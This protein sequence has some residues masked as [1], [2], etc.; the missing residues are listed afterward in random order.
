[1]MRHMTNSRGLVISMVWFAML[2]TVSS[3][4][5]TEDFVR[6]AN[7]NI[8]SAGEL[9][10]SPRAMENT[11]FTWGG[12]ANAG[13]NA[14]KGRDNDKLFFQGGAV[15]RSN[16]VYTLFDSTGGNNADTVVDLSGPDAAI[17]LD[18]ARVDS[19]V[20]EFQFLVRT[21]PGQWFIS[22]ASLFLYGDTDEIELLL[23]SVTW[24]DIT[25]AETVLDPLVGED[26][27]RLQFGS[28]GQAP[29]LS[30][31]DGGGIYQI[32]TIEGQIRLN[33][34]AWKSGLITNE[35]PSVEAGDNLTVYLTDG[36]VA[37]VNATATDDGMPDP[38][39]TLS[40]GWTV[41]EQPQGS[42]VTFTPSATVEDPL[43]TFDS[44]GVYVLQVEADDSQL[45]ATDTVTINVFAQPLET[46]ELAPLDDT[47]VRQ[48]RA[49][50]THG[51]S[52]DLRVRNDGNWTSYLKF[53]TWDVPGNPASYILKL[54]ARD[55]ID[56]ARVFP[57]TY[58]PSGEW[59]EDSL[60]WAS[61]DL[62]NGEVLDSIAPIVKGQYY[63]FNV[64][65]LWIESQ[66]RA[67]LGLT[68]SGGAN[69]DFGSKEASEEE[70][71]QLIVR[72][73]PK[74]ARHPLTVDGAVEVHPAVV[75]NWLSGDGSTQDQ[76]FL[77]TD[78]NNLERIGTV[79]VTGSPDGETLDPFG[80]DELE[81]GQ[82]YYWQIVG[83]N[84]TDGSVW[85]FIV[86]ALHPD[87]PR[88]VTPEDGAADLI[89]PADLTFRYDTLPDAT[90][91]MFNLYVSSDVTR[92]EALDESVKIANVHEGYDPDKGI[93]ARGLVDY[94]PLTTYFYRF[95]GTDASGGSWANAI[96]R[97][98]TGFY[99]GVEEFETGLTD[100]NRG[101]AWTGDVRG[102]AVPHSGASSLQLNYTS[103]PS[104][105]TATFDRARNWNHVNI[106]TLTLFV[107]GMASNDEATLSVTLEDAAGLSTTVEGAVD[108]TDEDPWQALD[109]GLAKF[110]I[111]LGAVKTLSVAVTSAGAGTVYI[112][113][114][115]LYASLDE[116]GLLGFLARYPFDLDGR[117]AGPG[118]L[119]LAL[120]T[121]GSGSFEIA[122][123]TAVGSGSFRIHGFG[124][125]FENGA[126]AQKPGDDNLAV[127][128]GITVSLWMKE[129]STQ[130]DSPW[131]GLFGEGLDNPSTMRL[132]SFQMLRASDSRLRWQC[133]KTHD[134]NAAGDTRIFY[135][136]G[137]DGPDTRDGKWHHIVGAYDANLGY[138]LY[139]DGLQRLFAPGTGLIND[140]EDGVGIIVGA[141]D[142]EEV[143]GALT[144]DPTHFFF[145]WID[146]ILVYDRALVP[147]EVDLIYRQGAIIE[148]DLNGDGILD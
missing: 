66:G 63:E 110:D 119:D 8:D 36:G 81:V 103:A 74:Q 26:E 130:P 87:M 51:S 62:V 31:V 73:N 57:A 117:D 107:R 78:P 112:D 102:A 93:D 65:G 67:T 22:D 20:P 129:D 90:P 69:K 70:M 32:H 39:A 142:H 47:F 116:T 99:A 143:N 11:G 30:A 34:I 82:T 145:G 44:E 2:T 125:D 14:I 54:Y 42:S 140:P 80:A 28:W 25:N 139:I 138:T 71:P 37:D 88:S 109:L 9:N 147:S 115:R 127:K 6:S 7:S 120:H 49:D 41:I 114:I 84:G 46:I 53:N 40:F 97:F 98:T 126:W 35:A 94:V 43:V 79:T 58:G 61:S 17:K 124:A 136:N 50:N 111:D 3:A 27:D 92:V 85:R 48:N 23:A 64:N 146:E 108:V 100:T 10:E 24:T 59:F 76:V 56:D 141:K 75:L 77:S 144:G 148:G 45:Q 104:I 55:D 106:E 137:D 134:P 91:D 68:S 15:T 101:V 86:M 12:F 18:L 52:A 5:V 128:T 96:K 95:E 133:A 105:A 113:D 16:Y 83:N 122:D 121:K 131:A 60:S 33:S 1:M 123:D 89:L 135:F 13:T 72:Y 132:Q 38:P 19:D 118:G 29:D 21:G 4:D